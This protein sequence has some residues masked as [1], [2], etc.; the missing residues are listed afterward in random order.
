MKN[1]KSSC[2]HSI[3]YILLF[4][5]ICGVIFTAVI[6]GIS[7]L[8]FSE[9]ANGSIIE[10]DGKKYG[11]ELL[12]QQYTD[13]SH[14]WGRIMNM[15]TSSFTDDAGNPVMYA[16]PSNLSPASEEFEQLIAERVEAIQE[17]NPEKSREPIPVDLVTCSG[18]S[19]DP[20]ISVAAA[21][22]QIERL[23]ANTDYSEEEI[24][25]I[26]DQCTT[27]KFLGLFGENYVNVLKVNLMLD[28][29]LKV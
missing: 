15:D 3:L 10:V 19:L 17:A 4:T 24:R 7:Q 23:A 12:G 20:G 8:F 18:S 16:A 21:Q 5:V 9:K 28:D 11:S 29:I 2:I 6:T 22:Y 27:H 1:F 26:I 13:D 25:S 14:M